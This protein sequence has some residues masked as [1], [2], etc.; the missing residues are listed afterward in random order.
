MAFSDPPSPPKSADVMYEWSLSKQTSNFVLN[1]NLIKK[2]V[3]EFVVSKLVVWFGKQDK[4]TYKN[5]LSRMQIKLGILFSPILFKS[6]SQLKTKRISC[7]SKWFSFSVEEIKTNNRYLKL[8][9][10]R[11]IQVLIVWS[12]GLWYFVRE[13]SYMT[14]DFWVGR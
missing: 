1:F 13:H 7:W 2:F 6:I 9:Q 5:E 12:D 10:T 14:S 8:V 11:R 3:L 4:R